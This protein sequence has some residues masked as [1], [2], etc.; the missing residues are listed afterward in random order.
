MATVIARV[1]FRH[2]QLFFV[3]RI[4]NRTPSAVHFEANSFD[5]LWVQSI[6]QQP[7]MP[8]RTHPVCAIIKAIT[9]DEARLPV[10][11]AVCLF[12]LRTET[13]RIL[14]V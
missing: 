6:I 13:R 14:E 8:F 10:F 11:Y 5:G 3:G 4:E 7:L 12:T 2:F 9:E 1:K